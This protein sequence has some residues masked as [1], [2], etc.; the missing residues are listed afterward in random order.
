[1]PRA[2]EAEAPSAEPDPADLD[3]QEFPQVLGWHPLVLNGEQRCA[4]CGRDLRRGDRGFLGLGD[5]GG[6]GIYLCSECL[7]TRS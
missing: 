6:T 3:R 2:A 1:M 7:D 5:S 4:D